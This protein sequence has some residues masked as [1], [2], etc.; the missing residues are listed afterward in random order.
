MMYVFYSRNILNK[1]LSVFY[2]LLILQIKLRTTRKVFYKNYL[3]VRVSCEKMCK[4]IS[5]GL[6]PHTVVTKDKNLFQLIIE[7]SNLMQ[8]D[9]SIYYIMRTTTSIFFI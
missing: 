5:T 3:G 7:I 8:F 4:T 6:A 1:K 9:Y 2:F